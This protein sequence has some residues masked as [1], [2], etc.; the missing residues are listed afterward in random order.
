MSATGRNVEGH[1]RTHLDFYET[2]G[3]ATRAMLPHLGSGSMDR[4]RD[5]PR[6][7]LDAGCGTG[8]IFRECLTCWPEAKVIGV[9]VEGARVREAARLMIGNLHFKDDRQQIIEED[10]LNIGPPGSVFPRHDTDK[11]RKW[12]LV[13]GNPPYAKA[14]EFIEHALEI[15][16]T[17]AFLLRIN[18]LASKK[19]AAF[20]KKF[21]ADLYVL[22]KRP[23][24]TNDNRTDATE[25]A[26]FVWGPGDRKMGLGFWRILDIDA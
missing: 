10:F 16:K 4:L 2:P 15:G 12:D 9:E 20:H 11:D 3:W 1:E 8:A 18:Y 22:P 17:I 13:I 25:Y 7:V 23:S 5:A 6:S 19:R 24:F 21:P 14:Q 26:W